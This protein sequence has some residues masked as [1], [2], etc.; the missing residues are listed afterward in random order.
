MDRQAVNK[1]ARTK[2]NRPRPGL[3]FALHM[4]MRRLTSIG[5]RSDRRITNSVRTELN[6]WHNIGAAR[7]LQRLLNGILGLEVRL[8][9][10]FHKPAKARLTSCLSAPPSP[11]TVRPASNA[12]RPGDEAPQLCLS[13]TSRTAAPGQR[14]LG[15]F[16]VSGEE[17]EH[18]GAQTEPAEDQRTERREQERLEYPCQGV[19]ACEK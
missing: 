19:P 6:F 5:A 9:F 12:P 2:R 7:R 4:N 3:P 17:V 14:S 18:V 16:T 13:G 1:K 15:E 8:P 11:S 10:Q